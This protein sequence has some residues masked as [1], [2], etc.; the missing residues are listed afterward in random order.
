ML[1]SDVGN[2]TLTCPGRR[3]K[4]VEYKEDELDELPAFKA[5]MYRALSANYLSQDRAD[6]GFAVKFLAF[7]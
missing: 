5:T 3:V 6:I 7:H 1:E 2:K 4:P